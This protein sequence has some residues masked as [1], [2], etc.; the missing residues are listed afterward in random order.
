MAMVF[1]LK[2]HPVKAP[3]AP[4]RCW[5]ELAREST[6]EPMERC[7]VWTL[8][9]S[10]QEQQRG[11]GLGAALQGECSSPHPLAVQGT[12]WGVTLEDTPLHELSVFLQKQQQTQ[13]QPL[14]PPLGKVKNLI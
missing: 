5:N 2:T 12:V 11:T 14:L 10:F 1:S 6:R 8:H 3:H 13:L 7:S 9:I 4:L